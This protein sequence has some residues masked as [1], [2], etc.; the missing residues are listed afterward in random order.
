MRRPDDEP[1]LEDALAKGFTELKQL[2]EN[3]PNPEST[4]PK[5]E[6]TP[7]MPA[8]RGKRDAQETRQEFVI[9]G[10]QKET[11]KPQVGVK[12]KPDSTLGDDF[13]VAW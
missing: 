9:K 8:F 5:E 4:I 6:A 2:D 12:Q 10:E 11:P 7:E 3:Q 13:D 1:T